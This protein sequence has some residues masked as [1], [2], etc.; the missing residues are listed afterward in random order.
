MKQRLSTTKCLSF[1]LVMAMLMSLLCVSVSAAGSIDDA[2]ASVATVEIAQTHN[3]KLNNNA[4][5]DYRSDGNDVSVTY[6]ASLRMTEEMAIYLQARQRLLYDAKFTVNI[7]VDLDN[8]DWVTNSGSENVVFTFKSSFLK[9]VFP[10]GSNPDGYD[11]TKYWPNRAIQWHAASG[12]YVTEI[13]AKTEYIR[14]AWEA[15]SGTISI[16]VELI[17]W[18]NPMHSYPCSFAELN[19]QDPRALKSMFGECDSLM[20]ADFTVEDWMKTITLET[21]NLKVKDETRAAVSYTSSVTITASGTVSGT[22]SYITAEN[23]TTISRILELLEMEKTDGMSYHKTLAFGT[24]TPE[25]ITD[26]WTSNEV[27]LRLIYS[28][29]NRPLPPDLNTEDHFAYIIGRTDGNGSPATAS[30]EESITRAEV[31]TIFFRMLKDDSRARNWSQ[32]NPYS[33]VDIDKW[34]NN[35]VST[36]SNMGIVNGRDGGVFAPDEPITRAE[37]ATIAVRFFDTSRLETLGDAFSDISGKWYTQYINYAAMLELVNG[38]PDGT[39]H[40]D[41]YIT[42]AEAMTIVN[43]TLRRTPV[44]ASFAGLKDMITWSDNMDT[45]KWYYAAV[46]EATNSHDY[47][48]SSIS[49][50]ETWT[51]ILPVRDWA[52]FEKAWSDAG[53]AGNPGDVV[54]PNP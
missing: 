1:V 11:H 7:K 22:F 27:V 52:A 26:A 18:D 13:A 50:P 47:K 41:D 39:Y 21:A 44:N 51:K 49:A 4:T 3:G 5:H 46:Q 33:D 10:V 28:T 43:N 24:G 23:T 34:Y 54:A 8:L 30:P 35:A 14:S 45:T 38:R 17:V 20:Y 25:D 9:P 42:R 36:L 12:C 31:A 6:A 40:P 29:S 16:P 32:T 53:S 15:G 37:F 2:K 48:R 19:A